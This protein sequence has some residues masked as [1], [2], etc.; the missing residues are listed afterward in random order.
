MKTRKIYDVKC[1]KYRKLKDSIISYIYISVLCLL[2][3]VLCL[4]YNKCGSND[5]KTFKEEESTEI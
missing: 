1:N 3:L 4:I 2:I 5:W